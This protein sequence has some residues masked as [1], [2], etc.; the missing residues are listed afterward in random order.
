[1][2]LEILIPESSLGEISRAWQC[3]DEESTIWQLAELLLL[4]TPEFFFQ[5]C[6]RIAVVRPG[7]S[8][9]LSVCLL[10]CLPNRDN[11]AYLL[12]QSNFR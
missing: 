8:P 1:M 3:L 12:L 5:L 2:R 4:G 11:N 9:L 7:A 6:H 10:T